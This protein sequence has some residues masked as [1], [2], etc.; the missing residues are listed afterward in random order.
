MNCFCLCHNSFA[1]EQGKAPHPP[2][3]CECTKDT[4]ATTRTQ[5]DLCYT[6]EEQLKQKSKLEEVMRLIAAQEPH[7]TEENAQPLVT[8][9]HV[10]QWAKDAAAPSL[11]CRSC[12]A[13]TPALPCVHCGNASA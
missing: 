1:I 10:V 7:A 8:L 4:N 2:S 12:R 9:Q 3:E 6:I 11:L 13:L 5:V